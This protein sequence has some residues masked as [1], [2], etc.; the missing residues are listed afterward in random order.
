M[1]VCTICSILFLVWP[2][3]TESCNTSPPEVSINGLTGNQIPP[4]DSGFYAQFQQCGV[5]NQCN[6]DSD[7]A[8]YPKKDRRKRNIFGTQKRRNGSM[9]VQEGEDYVKGGTGQPDFRFPWVGK[10]IWKEEQAWYNPTSP[11]TAICTASLISSR[12]V[13]TALHCIKDNGYNIGYDEKQTITKQDMK[14]VFGGTTDDEMTYHKIKEVYIPPLTPPKSPHDLAVV[15]IEEIVFSER[16]RP[17]C[18]PIYG[19]P[20]GEQVPNSPQFY[21]TLTDFVGYGL[22]GF[23]G[24]GRPGVQ[25]PVLLD[26]LQMLTNVT[27]KSTHH[28]IIEKSL[29][30]E[31]FIRIEMNE[32]QETCKG[33]SGGPLMWKHPDNG[34][35]IVLGTL[36]AGIVQGKK[37]QL[38]RV[39]SK[40]ALAV[41]YF[42]RVV[43]LLPSI[44][45]Y[46]KGGKS[47]LCLHK[48]CKR[49]TTQIVKRTWLANIKG[50]PGFS[51]VYQTLNSPCFYSEGIGIGEKK[52]APANICPV[53]SDRSIDIQYGKGS[54]NGWRTC[55]PCGRNESPDWD[56]SHFLDEI[57]SGSMSMP[58]YK[59]VDK[60]VIGIDNFPDR[61]NH[62]SYVDVCDT[63]VNRENEVLVCPETIHSGK[64]VNNKCLLAENICDGRNDCHD[65]WDESPHFCHGKCDVFH[66]YQYSNYTYKALDGEIVRLSSDAT[67]RECHTS[68][69]NDQGCTH[70]SYLG[71]GEHAS[72]KCKHYKGTLT[73][74]IKAITEP[75]LQNLLAI[76]G[77]AHCGDPEKQDTYFDCK[78][79]IGPPYRSGIFFIQSK[80]GR[81]LTQFLGTEVRLGLKS[82]EYSN[83]AKRSFWHDLIDKQ[84]YL[85]TGEWIL[86]FYGETSMA[87]SW[88]SIQSGV[89]GG[90]NP[91][92]FLTINNRVP[93]LQSK[94][95]NHHDE[96]GSKSQRWYIEQASAEQGFL[97]VRIF[98][99]L[100]NKKWYLKSDAT[101]SNEEAYNFDSTESRV[102]NANLKIESV[103]QNPFNK[104]HVFR[105]FECDHGLE[106]GVEKRGIKRLVIDKSKYSIVEMLRKSTAGKDANTTNA[107]Q[108]G[109]LR[110]VFGITHTRFAVSK[111]SGYGY[112][113]LIDQI[114]FIFQASDSL[115]D[116][117]GRMRIPSS[118]YEKLYTSW[119]E[120]FEAEKTTFEHGQGFWDMCQDLVRKNFIHG[121]LHNKFD[122]DGLIG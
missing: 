77:P 83:L 67:A 88:F 107:I 21:S 19:M 46:M 37:C 38:N 28:R 29:N 33:D 45:D 26:H 1:K 109:I 62:L 75:T 5:I 58:Q 50:V 18:L 91:I 117:A 35:Y 57:T 48:D 56:S 118:G 51:G 96:K 17:I 102:P 100:G 14:V 52:F 34:R 113:H 70:F 110:R 25:T 93:K 42:T 41:S 54:T 95:N 90:D 24:T 27:Q 60:P 43:E 104:G 115:L 122:Q 86:K 64:V 16:L 63:K 97:E 72:D 111:L 61:E 6:Q 59:G 87:D 71:L 108:E 69:Q 10:L 2:P 105:L 74:N 32:G 98:S 99:K 73:T 40:P 8:C 31:S 4:P 65:G 101:Y 49:E 9:Y 55:E 7:F 121:Y 80:A 39:S 13:L 106:T 89:T 114:S 68:C 103:E 119:T 79:T 53:G 84:L 20:Y 36:K 44:L 85:N 12:H 66:Q 76:R 120:A 47:N 11:D 94:I 15:R 112:T 3:E 30:L 23:R 92:Q 81:F 82:V 78:P 22:A 116:Y